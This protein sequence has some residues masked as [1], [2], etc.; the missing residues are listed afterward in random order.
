MGRTCQMW[1]TFK[2]T[3]EFAP[4]H[5]WLLRFFDQIR[6]YP[7]SAAEL[8]EF[9]SDFAHGRARL[10]IVP[11]RLRLGDYRKFLAD[12]AADIAEHKSRQQTAF[13]AERA[14]WEASGQ[15][16]LRTD[17]PEPES[18]APS[19]ELAPGCIAVSSPVAGSVWR[20]QTA[21][22]R[23]VKGGETLLL[24][25]SMKMELAVTAP[26]DGRVEEL[27]CSEGKSVLFAQTLVVLRASAARSVA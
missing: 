14:R 22:G 21:P 25:E 17:M 7:V 18:E 11:D 9:R 12:N 27:R 1:N 2:V 5:P 24:V 20:V 23:Y 4:D 3:R 16:G 15:S 26:V 13:N 10:D 19:E 8:L 6:F